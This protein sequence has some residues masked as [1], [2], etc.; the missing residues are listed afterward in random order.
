[1]ERNEDKIGIILL[2]MSGSPIGIRACFLPY[3]TLECYF[4][5]FLVGMLSSILIFC[6]LHFGLPSGL[7][8]KAV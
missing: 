5:L 8:T 3:E 1:M 2:R 7:C 6:H 4:Y